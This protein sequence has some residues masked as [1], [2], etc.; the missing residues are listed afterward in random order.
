MSQPKR[1]AT[2]EDLMRV[3]DTKVGEIVDG[4]LIVSPRPASA[5][6]YAATV[7]GGDLV[8]PF[9]RDPADPARPGG[10]WMLLEPELHFAD[11]VLVP[12]WTGWWRE[13]L[14]ILH[15]VPF[16]TL[17]PDWVCE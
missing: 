4:E 17:A 10:W 15:D 13:R 3:P 16:F 8:G 7:L 2:Y 1:R 6:S 11:V 12:D 9:N 14:P 5:H